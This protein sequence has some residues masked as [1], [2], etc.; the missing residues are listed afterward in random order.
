MKKLISTIF[1]LTTLFAG[2]AFAQDNAKLV[3][4][5]DMTL[6]TPQGTRNFPLVIKEEGGKLAPSPPFTSAEVKGTDVKMAMTVKFQD[7]DMVITY[8][9]KLEGDAMKGDADFGGF[10]QGTWSAKRKIAAASTPPAAASSTPPVSAQSGA[11]GAG[12]AGN[13]DM[14]IESP[15]GKRTLQLIIKDEGGKYSATVKTPQ[16]E[17]PLKS[18]AVSGS[19]IKLVMVREVQGQEMVM[20]YTGK[21]ASGKMSGDAD[22]GGLAT[23]T[24]EAVPHKEGTAA[25]APAAGPPAASAVNVTGVWNATV[26]TSQGSGN[27]TFT[28][29]QEG[30]NLTGNYKGQ[31]GEA[32]LKGSVKGNDISFMIKVNAQGQD[33]EVTYTG[34]VEGNTMKGKAVLGQL[35]EATWTAKKN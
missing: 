13:W 12:A 8:T 22:F 15:Q 35:G 24:W 2:A 32:P 7:A 4:T 18:V 14:T 29:K 19:D 3:G 10:A 9:G 17:A 25:A 34:K 20:T 6:E 27:P 28:F 11:S 1:V 21:I 26:E 23:G 16:G 30:E 31:L 5:W 33:F